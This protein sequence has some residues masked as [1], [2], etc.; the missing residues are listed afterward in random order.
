MN[1]GFDGENYRHASTHQKEWGAKLIGELPLQG[2]E[3]IL[4]LGSGDGT[5]TAQLASL[6]PRGRV[7]GI[8][9]SQSMIDAARRQRQPNLTFALLDINN[10]VYEAEFDLIFSNATLHWLPDHRN[11]LHRAFRALRQDGIL[12]W[13]FAADGNCSTFSRIVQAVMAERRYAG[14]FRGFEWPWHMPRIE[15]YR[16]LAGQ[17][18]FRELKVWGENADLFFPD[19][20]AMIRWIDQPSLV[21]FLACL[22]EIER[23]SFRSEVIERM[24]G[25][26][27]QEDGR[28]FERFARK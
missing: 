2:T 27:R 4:D 18:P 12:R 9:S 3:D 14:G 11:L 21:P 10:L 13:S 19:S 23:G 8:D 26:A 24:I 15:D 7:L 25:A 28:C 17:F 22:S 20:D 16:T 1:S 5:L 6:V